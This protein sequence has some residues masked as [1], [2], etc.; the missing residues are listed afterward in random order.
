M[1]AGDDHLLAD[2]ELLFGDGSTPT[3][4]EPARAPASQSPPLTMH[5]TTPPSSY[6]KDEKDAPFV[7]TPDP[8]DDKGTDFSTPAPHGMHSV[9]SRS[10]G[11][12]DSH[13][14]GHRASS[15]EPTSG[16]MLALGPA[17]AKP[18]AAAAGEG[19]RDSMWCCFRSRVKPQDSG[20]LSRLHTI[21]VRVAYALCM[22]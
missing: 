21:S 14:L 20:R 16:E 6:P 17:E 11:D 15:P 13:P 7:S 1:S 9:G 22:C 10:I 18:A 12:D 5:L 19:P 3:A 8:K 4:P 2:A